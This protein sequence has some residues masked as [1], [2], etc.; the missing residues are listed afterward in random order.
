MTIE[1]VVVD[2]LSETIEQLADIFDDAVPEG[3]NV[4]DVIL[5]LLSLVAAQTAEAYAPNVEAALE[6][7]EL[8][9]DTLRDMT[10]ECM[11]PTQ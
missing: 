7:T 10:R 1:T 3:S 9:C 6:A 11:G 8:W 4:S 5:A 2:P